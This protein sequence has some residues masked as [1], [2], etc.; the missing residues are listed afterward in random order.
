MRGLKKVR[1]E[2]SLTVLTY[3]LRRVLNLVEMPRRLAALGGAGRGRRGVVRGASLAGERGSMPLPASDGRQPR[4]LCNGE[5][6]HS[7]AL[8]LTASS[9]VSL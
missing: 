8:H 6:S 7:L 1:T 4:P 5:L 3:T 2:L 9:L